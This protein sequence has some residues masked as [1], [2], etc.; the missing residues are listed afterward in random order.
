MKS[1]LPALL[2]TGVTAFAQVVGSHRAH[3]WSTTDK[4][5][6]DFAGNSTSYD[7]PGYSTM[8]A[9]IGVSKDD[10]NVQV[11]GTNL[12]DTRGIVFSTFTQWIKQDTVIRPRTITLQFGY[13]FSTR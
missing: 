10:W 12:T 5:R 8:D 13:K 1:W 4:L 7:M 6:T 11:Y 3:S 9:S 2:L